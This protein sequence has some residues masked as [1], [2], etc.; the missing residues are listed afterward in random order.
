MK[1]KAKKKK[2]KS[3]HVPPERDCFP[4]EKDPDAMW[5]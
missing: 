2:E 4:A 5:L 1:K 3:N